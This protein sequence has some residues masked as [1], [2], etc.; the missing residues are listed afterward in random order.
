MSRRIAVLTI[1]IAIG[2]GLIGGAAPASAH[3]LTCSTSQFAHREDLKRF[4]Q[5]RVD[6][7]PRAMC[8]VVKK[9]VIQFVAPEKPGSRFIWHQRVTKTAESGVGPLYTSV[10]FT[11]TRP[12]RTHFG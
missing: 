11:I 6:D 5:L 12:W 2:A 9:N 10:R 8:F 1:T 7:M 4:S 3:D